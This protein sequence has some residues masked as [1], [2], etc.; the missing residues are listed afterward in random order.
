[1]IKLIVWLTL[2]SGEILQA[3][4]LVVNDPESNGALQGQFRYTLE[5]LKHQKAFAL[6]PFHLPL[7][8]VI[9]DVHRPHAGV[10]AVFEDS[11]PDDWGRRLLVRRYRLAINEQR[12]PNL[13]RLL[14]GEGLGGL[15]FGDTRHPKR[16][17]NVPGHE[18]THLVRLAESF[19]NNNDTDDDL[20]LLFEAGS[21][22]GG[23]RPKVVVEYNGE[24]WLAKFPSV[25]DQFDVVALEASAM[26][27]AVKAGIRAATTEVIDCASKKVLLVKRFDVTGH[28]GRKHLVSMQTLLGAEGYY[29]LGYRDLADIIRRI[30]A[31]PDEDLDQLFRQ[32]AFNG[33][34]GNT[35]DH[36]KNFCMLHGEDGWR[37][38]P[39]FDLLPNVGMNRS[40]QL[41]IGNKFEPPNRDTLI[42]EAK[43]FGIKRQQKAQHIIDEVYEA[44]SSWP[45]LFIQHGVPQKDMDILSKD[46]AH[47]LNNIK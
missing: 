14:G 28:N 27:L 44:V 4:E 38:S 42:G 3:G 22:P 39:A 15:S 31:N 18:L 33:M 7:S 16:N 43:N 12:V 13:L 10:H 24:S 46:I 40:H 23:A 41:Y 2:E 34:I 11:L 35:D 30:S 8:H 17:D 9:Y 36:L 37:L 29:H 45:A 21:S 32:L 6:D 20:A 47:R 25:R 1:M 5:Y 19:E 26:D